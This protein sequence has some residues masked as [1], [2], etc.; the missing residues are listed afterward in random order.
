MESGDR[1]AGNRD[2]HERP[3]RQ[4]FRMQILQGDFGDLIAAK[5]NTAQY[6]DRH[7][8]QDHAE[9]G[10]QF[11]DQFVDRQQCCQHIVQQDHNNPQ[12]FVQEPRRQA[13]DQRRRTVDKDRT[14]KDQQEHGENPH[15]PS[16]SLPQVHAR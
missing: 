9:R 11:P 1:A 4:P 3:D 10:I 5:D 16:G 12:V 15:D 6:A 2:K 7:H 13:R 8:D 14:A